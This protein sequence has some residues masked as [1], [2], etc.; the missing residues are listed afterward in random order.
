MDTKR[1]NLYRETDRRIAKVSHIGEKEFENIPHI[2]AT[3]LNG[4]CRSIFGSISRLAMTIIS[5]GSHTITSRHNEAMKFLGNK[6]PMEETFADI[7][8]SPCN[9]L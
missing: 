8:Q 1:E 4:I 9:R 7:K 3:P 6:Y 2:S 5:I